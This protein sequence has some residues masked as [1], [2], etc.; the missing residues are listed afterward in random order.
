MAL[1]SDDSPATLRAKVTSPGGTTE[2]AIRVFEQE[3][4]ERI[5]KKAMT[6]ARDRSIELS[7]Q[8]PVD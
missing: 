2:Q 3:G 6:A 7:S 8:L 4:L 5:L 1:E